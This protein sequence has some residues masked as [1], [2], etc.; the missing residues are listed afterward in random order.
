[1][2]SYVVAIPKT[3]A[4]FPA[5]VL[6]PYRNI[7]LSK[8]TEQV[9]GASKD[10]WIGSLGGSA[11]GG[12]AI[13]RLSPRLLAGVAD[14][15]WQGVHRLQAPSLSRGLSMLK[16]VT[17]LLN[18]PDHG[19]SKQGQETEWAGRRRKTVLIIEDD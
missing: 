16:A 10:G 14:P 8:R 12:T 6:Y 1:M 17:S 11:V 3:P 7:L 5:Q 4:F 19:D 18:K 15:L 9:K 2:V 13:A